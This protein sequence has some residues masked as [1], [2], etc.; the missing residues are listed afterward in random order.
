MSIIDDVMSLSKTRAHSIQ[1]VELELYLTDEMKI[2][3][4]EVPVKATQQCNYNGDLHTSVVSE[5]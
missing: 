1:N 2:N 5:L 4:S 3:C